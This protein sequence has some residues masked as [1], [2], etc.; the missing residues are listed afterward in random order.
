MRFRKWSEPPVFSARAAEASSLNVAR[1]YRAFMAGLRVVTN[2]GM[3]SLA[4]VVLIA[5]AVR[6]FGVFKGSLDWAS[7]YS[8]FGIIWVVML[9]AAVAFDQ[10]AH[11]AIDF[12]DLLSPRLRRIIR[13]AAYLCGICFVVILA[14]QGFRLSF[15][16]MRQISPALGIPIGYAYL[17][18]P[19][20]AVIM[21]AQSLLFAVTPELRERRPPLDD[22]GV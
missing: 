18:L 7:E 6:Y 21:A 8:R 20:G 11:V 3:V 19:V 14:W 15:A 17:A 2:A 22:S 16:T 12:T 4:V 13:T 9:G 1:V 5:V 10:G